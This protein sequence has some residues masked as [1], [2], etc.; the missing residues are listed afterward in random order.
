MTQKGSVAPRRERN[1]SFVQLVPGGPTRAMDITCRWVIFT[2]IEG[3]T[4]LMVRNARRWGK[5]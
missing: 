4:F 5:E 3:R 2:L 1:L